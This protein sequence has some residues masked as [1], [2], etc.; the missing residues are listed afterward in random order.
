MPPP[1]IRELR[2]QEIET[3]LTRNHVG[4]IAYVLNERVDIEPINYVYGDGWIYCRTSPGTKV[5][6]IQ[7]RRRVAFEVDESD[8]RFHWRSVVVHGQVDFRRPTRRSQSSTRSF[9]G[10]SC[11]ASWSPAR[12]NG[13]IPCRFGTW[14]SAYTLTRSRVGRRCRSAPQQRE[15]A[16]RPPSDMI[17]GR[18]LTAHARTQCMLRHAIDATDSKRGCDGKPFDSSA[19]TRGRSHSRSRGGSR[20]S[21]NP[22]QI[23][24]WL[25]KRAPEPRP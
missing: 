13:T 22:R 25:G 20:P 16:T 12:A 5:A 11:W 2:R 4:R 18:S 6:A 1:L 9:M 17:V 21:S 15:C 3:I 23:S 14:F 19:A 8:G 24:K 7:Q 10:S